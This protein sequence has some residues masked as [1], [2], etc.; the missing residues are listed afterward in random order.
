[1]SIA[2]KISVSV[3]AALVAG[4][5]SAPSF[6]ADQVV[7]TKKSDGSSTVFYPS[8]PV[9]LPEPLSSSSSNEE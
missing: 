4:V 8:P 9:F 5:L 1:M 6:A 7:I 2:K 3:A